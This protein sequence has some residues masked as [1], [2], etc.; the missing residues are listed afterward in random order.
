MSD[1]P[2]ERLLFNEQP[3]TRIGIDYSA[4]INVDLTRKTRWN[5][6][7][8]KQYEAFLPAKLHI[9]FTWNLQVIY[10]ETYL[11]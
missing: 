4:S 9:P 6:V 3:F 10:L 7:K 5:Q 2:K 8:H 1:L 11:Y